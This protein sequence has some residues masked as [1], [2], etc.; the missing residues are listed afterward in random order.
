[1]P[2]LP[3]ESSPTDQSDGQWRQQWRLLWDAPQVALLKTTA[4]NQISAA[5]QAA[6]VLLQTSA[7]QLDDVLFEE[8]F[9][10]LEPK[11]GWTDAEG[12]NATGLHVALHDRSAQCF[13][14]SLLGQLSS[15]GKLWLLEA[16]APPSLQ[17]QL[18]SLFEQL[19]SMV[20]LLNADRK[21]IFSNQA[22]DDH[23]NALS[24]TDLTDL[25]DADPF[26]SNQPGNL[27]LTSLQTGFC[28]D[29]HDYKSKRHFQVCDLPFD[30]PGAPRQLLLVAKNISEQKHFQLAL[31]DSEAEQRFLAQQFETLFKAIPDALLLIDQD[32]RIVWSNPGA[33]TLL[34]GEETSLDGC[35]YDELFEQ[36]FHTGSDCVVRDCFASCVAS[37]GE[38]LTLDGRNIVLRAFPIIADD[39]VVKRVIL[40]AADNSRRFQQRVNAMRTGQ[41]AAIGELAAGVAH[42]IN[43]PINGIMNYAQIL[44]NK[45]SGVDPSLDIPQRIL[46]ESE[47][48]A[49]IVRRL[50]DFCR[51][52]EERPVPHDIFEVINNILILSVAQMRTEGIQLENRIPKKLPP[53]RIRQQQIEQVLL[54]LLNNARFSLNQ[55]YRGHH[56]EKMI[57]IDAELTSPEFVRLVITDHGNG[58]PRHL[59][60]KVFTPFFTTKPEGQGTGLGLNICWQIIREHKGVMDIDSLPGEWTRVIVDLPTVDN[61]TARD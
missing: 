48:V 11:T 7:E 39:G 6:T 24:K 43:N 20:C 46:V 42:E 8:Q 50:L 22:F 19:N 9:Q 25:L 30:L 15:G 57:E 13:R 2:I 58:I 31:Q 59:L 17:T 5:N 44:V 28:W 49:E 40:I 29:W 51:R 52:K 27:D 56:Q 45:G 12:S 4:S 18:F 16:D 60:K 32:L 26:F 23:F 53:V 55:K 35:D 61:E 41:L 3:A 14:L 1:M 37:D 10:L 54:N 38:I 33:R 47:R 34:G 21:L 36:R